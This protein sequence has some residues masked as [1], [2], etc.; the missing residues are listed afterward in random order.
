MNK[1]Q[2]LAFVQ[3]LP[4]D[5]EC[6]PLNLTRESIERGDWFPSDD[7]TSKINTYERE[8]T[9]N[10]TLTLVYKLT[11]AAEFKRTYEDPQG[12]FSNLR[13]VTK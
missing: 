8:V 3:S 7:R 1:E 11:Q 9:H 2:L 13:R 6:L 5:A 12:V 10:L 4:D